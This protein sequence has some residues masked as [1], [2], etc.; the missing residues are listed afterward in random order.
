M[1]LNLI[2]ALL[3]SGLKKTKAIAAGTATAIGGHKERKFSAN[4]AR[5]EIAESW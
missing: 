5:R 2:E 1:M 3:P 4:R